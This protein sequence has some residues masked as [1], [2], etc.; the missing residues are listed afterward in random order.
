MT[1]CDL[2]LVTSIQGSPAKPIS[3]GRYYAANAKELSL[4]IKGF[5]QIFTWPSDQPR[6][7]TS[8]SNS[9]VESNFAPVQSLPHSTPDSQVRKAN[10]AWPTCHSRPRPKS[11]RSIAPTGLTITVPIHQT[12]PSS[13]ATRGRAPRF[14]DSQGLRSCLQRVGTFMQSKTLTQRTACSGGPEHDTQPT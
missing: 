8:R 12:L 11:A 4:A 13:D 10:P 7:A 5:D 1:R 14:A 6:H 9:P 3:R 2:E